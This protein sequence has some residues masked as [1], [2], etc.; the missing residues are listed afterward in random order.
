MPLEFEK[1]PPE[2][3]TSKFIRSG[4]SKKENQF[5]NEELSILLANSVIKKCD[6]E[7]GEYISPIFLTPK[8]DGSFRLILNL[9]KLNEYMPYV[10]FRIDTIRSILSHVTPSCFMSKIDIKGDA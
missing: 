7:P 8:S 9:K 10:H 3:P 6:H 4:F 5:I 2:T 1:L